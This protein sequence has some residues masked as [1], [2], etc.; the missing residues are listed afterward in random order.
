M[1]LNKK[2]VRSFIKEHAPKITQVEKDFFPALDLQTRKL[3]LK[4]LKRNGKHARLT[5]GE[6]LTL[7]D[8]E[9]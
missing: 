9:E 5:Q 7:N 6:L 2:A 3:I 4:A 1:L 8:K